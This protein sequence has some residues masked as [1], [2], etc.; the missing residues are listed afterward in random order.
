MPGR[1]ANIPDTPA[2]PGPARIL[3]LGLGNTLLSDEAVGVRVVEAVRARPEAAGLTCLDGGTMGL[4]LLIEMEDAD[5]LIIVDAARL[6]ALPGTMRLFEGAEM[7]AF[8]R[9]RGINPHDIGLEDLM[10]A[11]RLREALPAH[12]ALVG[13]EPATL[14]VGD[15][16]SPDVARAVPDA[17]AAVLGLIESWR[18]G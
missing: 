5:A 7:D 2:I 11:L 15:G 14:A 8:M 18:K 3:V 16:L 10:D 17:V 6:E 9:T 13:I 1:N 12:R 4:S